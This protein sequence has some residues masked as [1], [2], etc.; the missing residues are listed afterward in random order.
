MFAIRHFLLVPQSYCS[1]KY[2]NNFEIISQLKI[3]LKIGL[4]IV[5]NWHRFKNCGFLTNYEHH[6]CIEPFDVLYT[7]FLHIPH[8]NQ[9]AF[10]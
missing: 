3:Y 2:N 4:K 1:K 9:P 5:S 10:M 7:Q 6:Y 8:L